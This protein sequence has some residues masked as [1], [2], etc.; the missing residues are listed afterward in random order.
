MR[1]RSLSFLAVLALLSWPAAG[2]EQKDAQPPAAATREV[3]PGVRYRAGGLH[4]FF[5]GAHYRNLWAAPLTAEVLDLRTFSGG[6]TARKKGGG[7]QTLSLK[8]EGADGREWKFRSLDKDPS[9][10]LPPELRDTFVDAIVQDQ[11]SAANPAA[12][13]VVD[14]LSAT[15]GI[16]HVPHRLV[17]LP[18]DPLLG[19]FQREFGGQLGLLEE[20]IKGKDPDT[21]GFENMSRVLD[22]LELWKRLD[23]HAE[24][25]VDARA[26]LKARLFDFFLGDFDRHKDQ[27]QWAKPEGSQLWLP[28]PEDRD[29]ATAKYDGFL[30]WLIRPAQPTLVD[31]RDRYPRTIGLA[32][33]ARFLDR[34]HLSELTW[35]EW[36][37]V[38]K[39]LQAA[40]TDAAI[41]EAVHQLPAEHYRLGG[42]TLSRRLKARRT[43]LPEAARRFYRMLADQVEIH[44]SDAD[45]VVTISSPGAGAVEVTLAG[46]QGETHFQRR[47]R[48]DETREVRLHLKGGDDRVERAAG[49]GAITMR[50]VGGAGNDA[51]DDTREGHTTLYD[52]GGADRVLAGPGT[53]VDRRPY[54]QAL[55][56]KKDPARDWGHVFLNTPLVSAGGD[57]GV[58]VGDRASYIG[59]GFR[60]YP[61]AY[62]HTVRGGYATGLSAA[63]VEYEGQFYR[64][65][66][67]TY[68]QL[69]L[70]ASQ[71]DILRFYG[72]GNQ[73]PALED[74]DFFRVEQGRI[75]VAPSIHFGLAHGEL[76]LGLV[77][78]H[79]NTSTPAQTFIGA[80]RPYGV[81]D[82]GQV[83]VHGRLLFGE[84]NIDKEVSGRIWAGGAYYP[85]AWDVEDHFGNLQGEAAAYLAP[86]APLSPVLGLRLGT[87]KVFGRFPFFEA[88]FVG[89]PDEVRGLRPQR[90]AGDTAAF[91]SAELHLRLF[92]ARILLPTQVGVMGLADIGRVWVDGQTSDSWHKGV[93]G[94]IW[95]APLRRSATV[96]VAMARS[97]GQTR[98]YFQGGF[99]F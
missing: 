60:K 29:Q 27:W 8:F 43:R 63:Q 6:L 32:W 76:E 42:D 79:S 30:L 59:Y 49:T 85:K 37:P 74:P 88:A 87:K 46:P 75:E 26:Y 28:V 40:L 12:P 51:L 33:Q 11:I 4:R 66:S 89:G 80:T 72:L 64:T 36:E 20:D 92:E 69:H 5:F 67:R 81:G 34:R 94:G 45:D 23:A 38:V 91:G 62:R 48:P 3:V 70:R 22:T 95:F 47:F 41:D 58:F 1:A 56:A 96:T 68:S 35:A 83:G 24:E 93:G 44:G 17:I 31:F 54:E 2:Q 99:G 9:A 55:D 14:A 39:E 10:V 18:D 57:L 25:K 65:A 13:L 84:R 82:F 21:P 61:F 90:Y 53:R 71:I 73:T 19:T 16:L 97:E 15:A 78:A 52:S 86:R 77:A 98:I 7:K 50:V